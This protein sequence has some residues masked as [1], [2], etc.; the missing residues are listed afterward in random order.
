MAGSGRFSIISHL[1]HSYFSIIS[2]IFLD[3]FQFLVYLSLIS[4]LFHSYFSIISHL[5]LKFFPNIYHF[6]VTL[7]SYFFVKLWIY[8]LY[9]VEAGALKGHGAVFATAT[10]YFKKLSWFF[11]SELP[12]TN[13]QRIFHSWHKG[14]QNHGAVTIDDSCLIDWVAIIPYT[15][16][17]WRGKILANL[18]NSYNS[19][20]FYPPNV[21][22]LPSK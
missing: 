20:N 17:T 16:N 10:N 14:A 11:T 22:V 18:A 12:T 4:C 2:L 3:Y 5:F 9:L 6:S 21:L 15:G 8:P 1:F 7:P 19:P 13:M